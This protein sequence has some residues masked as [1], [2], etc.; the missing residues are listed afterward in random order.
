MLKNKNLNNF[1]KKIFNKRAKISIMGLGYVGLP[2]A[3][4]FAKSGYY[5][6]GYDVDKFK[7]QS[8]KKDNS[9]ISSVTNYYLAKY[10]KKFKSSSNINHVKNSDI[11]VI[12]VP[13][14][15]NEKKLPILSHVKDVMDKLS[16]I[17]IKDKLVIFECTSYPGTTEEY[18]LPFVKKKKIKNWF[19]Y[20]FRL[21]S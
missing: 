3:L 21:L 7:I 6:H 13:T 2:L 10:K 16:T 19:R 9:Y 4:S 5:V 12:C 18:F 17:E 20:F 11:I 8:I 1:K 15:I 14:P